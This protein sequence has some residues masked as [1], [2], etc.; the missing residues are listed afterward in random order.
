MRLRH[1]SHGFVDFSR[2]H[3]LLALAVVAATVLVV[4]Q[5]VPA[6][7]EIPTLPVAPA[8]YAKPP[9][10]HALRMLIVWRWA[11]WFNVDTQLALA[12][13]RVENWSGR[14]TAVSPTGC[15]VGVM[16]VHVAVWQGHFPQ[17]GQDLLDMG[18]NACYGVLILKH[19]LEVCGGDVDCALQLYGGWG[20]AT[21]AGPYI[22]KVR[23][24]TQ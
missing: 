5:Q 3:R 7:R 8:V 15:C 9:T 12:V 14:P 22:E 2:T 1:R 4:G 13:S 11:S 21:R 24:Y 18:T 19:Y 17:C 16:Q 6:A 20:S 23:G 10:Q